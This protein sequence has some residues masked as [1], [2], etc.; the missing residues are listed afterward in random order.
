MSLKKLF[1]LPPKSKENIVNSILLYNSLYFNATY[2]N[3]ALSSRV[4]VF[5]CI[6]ILRG[7]N[8]RRKKRGCEGMNARAIDKSTNY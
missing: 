5:L 7:T 8:N 2:Y 3:N 1:L 4:N 6:C